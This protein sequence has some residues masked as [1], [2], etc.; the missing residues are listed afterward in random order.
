MMGETLARRLDDFAVIEL[1]VVRVVGRDA[2]ERLFA[3]MGPPEM[4]RD[5]D[6]RELAGRQ[7]RMLAA[8]RTQDW[9]GAEAALEALHGPFGLD[10]VAK[11]Y[12]GRIA[13]YRKAPPGK[14]WDGVFEATEK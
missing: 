4:A 10:S 8:Y 11:L 13:A 9:D 12:A 7:A 2:P 1:D 5:V 3:L 14:D 6:F